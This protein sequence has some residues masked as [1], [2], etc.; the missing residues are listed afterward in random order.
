VEQA[1][2]ATNKAKR[3]IPAA[4]TQRRRLNQSDSNNIFH[5]PE[6]EGK[7]LETVEFITSSDYDAVVLSFR[8]NTCLNLSIESGFSLQAYYLDRKGGDHRVLKRW[9][10][11]PT[12]RYR[13]L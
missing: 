6:A 2:M 11:M 13:K 7:V 8:D 1:N 10:P 5:F 4:Q 3:T 9:P 12:A